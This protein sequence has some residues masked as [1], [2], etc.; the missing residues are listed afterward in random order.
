M[1]KEAPKGFT[2]PKPEG[3]DKLFDYAERLAKPFPFVRTD[4]Y[5]ENGKAYFGELT[6]TPSGGFDTGRLPESDRLF[7]SMVKL[8]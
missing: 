3:I 6:F 1:G 8:K 2:I 5:L 7:G 4:F